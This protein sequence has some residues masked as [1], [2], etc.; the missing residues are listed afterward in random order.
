[1]SETAFFESPMVQVVVGHGVDQKT[2]H[3]HSDLLES[4]SEYF[5]VSLNSEFREGKTKRVTLEKDKSDVFHSFVQWLYG[6][7]YDV[8]SARNVENGAGREMYY[9][10]Q[11]EAYALGNKLIAPAFKLY[12]VKTLLVDL[13]RF[14]DLSMTTL[15]EMVQTVYGGTSEKDGHDMRLALAT[16]CLSRMGSRGLQITARGFST[17]EIDELAQTDQASFL[18]DVLHLIPRGPRFS[19]QDLEHK[20]CGT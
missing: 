20:L 16:Y 15:L 19:A 5:K 1:M 18:R 8:R 7:T 11:A 13:Q 17:S 12:I 14:D 9:G 4:Q 10:F 3:V 6:G 2:F